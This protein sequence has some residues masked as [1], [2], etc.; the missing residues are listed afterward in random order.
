MTTP[1]NY[2]RNINEFTLPS[3]FDY[4]NNTSKTTMSNFS[5][6]N[7]PDQD[8]YLNSKTRKDTKLN[9]L[10]LAE[11]TRRAMSNIKSN[12]KDTETKLLGNQWTTLTPNLSKTMQRNKSSR[13]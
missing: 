9:A 4:S 5:L 12:G 13:T 8:H 7:S 3:M 6:G 11:S 10:L 2:Q 1:S